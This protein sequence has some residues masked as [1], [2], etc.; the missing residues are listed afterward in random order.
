MEVC[1]Y[2]NSRQ[3]IKNLGEED[4]NK[5]YIGDDID[6]LFGGRIWRGMC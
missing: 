6:F 1:E 4:E 5:K 2:K 3:Q